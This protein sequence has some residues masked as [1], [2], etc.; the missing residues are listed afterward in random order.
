MSLSR[1]RIQI[2]RTTAASNSEAHTEKQDGFETLDITIND[3][4][5]NAAVSTVPPTLPAP[6]RRRC[7][8]SSSRKG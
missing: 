1:L 3:V 8:A 5:P 7:P 6:R 2:T 4:K